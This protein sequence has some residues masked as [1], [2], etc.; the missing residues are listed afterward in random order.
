[1]TTTKP[2]R[3]YKKDKNFKGEL[4]IGFALTCHTFKCSLRNS[5]F[6]SSPVQIWRIPEIY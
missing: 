3:L 2:K 1:M 6:C 4:S 5:L